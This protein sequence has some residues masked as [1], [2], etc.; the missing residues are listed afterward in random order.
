MTG[1]STV[2]RQGILG[3]LGKHCIPKLTDSDL[4]LICS[5]KEI[6]DIE[7]GLD[8]QLRKKRR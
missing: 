1:S 5:R 7:E 8:I 6:E 2:V 4:L 3:G